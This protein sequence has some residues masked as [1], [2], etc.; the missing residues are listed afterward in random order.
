[1]LSCIPTVY[2]CASAISK[3]K[4]ATYSN[5]CLQFL[6]DIDDCNPNPCDNGGQCTDLANGYSC[7]CAPGYTGADCKTG[8]YE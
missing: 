5:G 4:C 2:L 1:M 6:V 7:A 8:E 3:T